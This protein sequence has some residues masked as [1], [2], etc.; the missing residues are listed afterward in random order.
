MRIALPPDIDPAAFVRRDASAPVLTTGGE[1]MGT[2]WSVR[3]ARVPGVALANV[4]V[5]VTAR[6]GGIVA[7]MSH[8][9]P[10]TCLSRFNR[11]EPGS[12]VTLPPDFATVMTAALDIAEASDGAFDPAIGAL[13]DMWGFGPV[14]TAEAPRA[15]AIAEAC[16]AGGWRRLAWRAPDRA[17]RQPGD[18]R[19]DLSGIAKGF[20]V[21]AVAGALRGLGL[22]DFL[23]EIGGELFGAGVRPDG[24]PW[25]VDLETPPGLELPPLRIALHGLAVATSGNSR[26]GEHTIDPR[27]GLGASGGVLAASVIHTSAMLADAWAT[28]LTVLGPIKGL[29]MADRIGLAARLIVAGSTARE[30]LSTAL[31]A[32]L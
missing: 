4:R 8:W 6:L 3:F 27:T 20:A 18:L 29:E 25:W 19:L 13:V 23:V 28:A 17:L 14:P 7:E 5:A 16:A 12:W 26:R 30:H 11:A 24:E 22:H 2:C 10:A 21:D 9:E 1:T 31:V 15:E 32:M